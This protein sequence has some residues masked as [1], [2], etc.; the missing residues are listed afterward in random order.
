MTR[1][2]LVLA[3]AGVW[4]IAGSSW[5]ATFYVDA[6]GGN[7]VNDGLSQATAWKTVAKVNGNTFA[8]GDQILFKRG[9]VWNES[10]V[11]PSSGVS[12]NPIAFDAYGTGEA[13]TLTGYVGLPAASW[14]L[15]SGNIW[16][17]SI[18]SSSF[19]YVLFGYVG[20]NG[21]VGSVWGTKF[22]T[23]KTQLVAP[24]QFFFL[25]NVLYVYALSNPAT[26]YGSM[27]AMLMTNG[28]IIYINGK[29][30][31]TIQHFRV[32]YFD[33]Y[34]VRIGGA[35][36]HITIANVYSDGV[37]PAGTTP[38]GFYVSASP[39]PT[40]MKFY[41]VDAHRNYNGFRFDGLGSGIVVKN[42]RA[43]GNRNHGLE[44]NMTGGGSAYSFCHFYA[45]G[46]GVVT[47]T[48][49]VG[50]TNGGNNIAAYTA[51][52]TMSFQKYPARITLTVDDPGLVGG[53]D[54]YIDGILPLFDARG[55]QLSVAI[56][57]G[58][59]L[60]N[61]L[62]SKFQS[63]ITAGRDVVSHSWSHQ[64]F[65]PAPAFTIKYTGTG[66]AAAMTISGTTLSTTV[67]GGPGGENLSFDLTNPSF[68][69]VSS[70]VTAINTH[71][72]YT[73]SLVIL[74]T[75]DSVT[76]TPV[77]GQ[78]IKSATFTEQ[79]RNASAFAMQYTGTGSAATMTISGNL[80]TTTVTGG[81]GGE[82]LSF[83]LT[84]ASY[85]T[86]SEL[87]AAISGRSGYTATLASTGK[88][89]AHTITLADLAAQD[90]RSAQ[91]ITQVLESR[92]EPDEMTTSKAW[93]NANLTG[94]PTN[95]AL[96][97]PGGQEDSSTQG[98]AATA[99]YVGARGAFTMDLGTKDVYAR[100]VN[101]QNITSFGANPSLQGLSSAQLDAIIAALVW[102]S[103]VWGAPYG[104][105]WHLSEFP[106]G[107]VA[108]LLDALVNHGATL[109]TNTQLINW[110][111]GQSLS[112]TS[113]YYWAAATGLEGDMRPTKSAPV[114]DVGT[115]LGAGFALDL[116]GVDQRVFGT[117][118]EMGTYTV[119]GQSPFLVVE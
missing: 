91:Y 71:S 115:D 2:R 88:G 104:V 78:D 49:T 105:F 58:Y 70:L 18:T 80:L 48:D 29:S 114:V 100:G 77:A 27:A 85:D 72:G 51:P 95:R 54:T 83:D 108:T 3:V 112:G 99:G 22:T 20:S 117:G 15:D 67:T 53:A 76:L 90:I 74:P 11:P 26:Y 56:V 21:N 17:T 106:S 98:Y 61:T 107:D 42:C 79:F 110:V 19:N 28:Q 81:P 119:V 12:G 116:E 82:N 24:Y 50:G 89:A 44:D 9:G 8:A 45:N 13:P 57:T 36:D 87:T 23:S 52:K 86:M 92:L 75:T 113:N 59:A 4:L 38:H 66:S 1:I 6:A 68:N 111:A 40:D 16:K 46:L 35:S 43:Y 62:I 34:G 63:W 5:A 109:M 55:I 30:W 69:T 32:T 84:N 64:Y 37:I 73:A 39:A 101:I 25:S 96:V 60:S 65:Q 10:L 33:T 102:K 47:S 7:D 41:N 93:M 97:Y 14:T 31:L 94:L 103:S 118:W